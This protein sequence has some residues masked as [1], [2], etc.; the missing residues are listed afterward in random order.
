M[1]LR[2]VFVADILFSG[3]VQGV[4]FR[5]HTLKVAREFDVSGTVRNLAD[6]RVHLHAEG[7]E[8][9]VLAFVAAVEDEMKS[10]IRETEKKTGMGAASVS[11]FSIAG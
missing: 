11:G 6:G 3:R 1:E 2:S 10:F 9:D 7:A 8:R 5:W 4:G